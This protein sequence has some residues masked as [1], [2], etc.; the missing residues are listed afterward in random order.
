[1]HIRV[2]AD[3]FWEVLRRLNNT[4][5][6]RFAVAQ[7]PMN[8]LYI[9]IYLVLNL[10]GGGDVSWQTWLK[11]P[12]IADTTTWAL[13]LKKQRNPK[14]LMSPPAYF[15]RERIPGQKSGC[16]RKEKKFPSEK[17]CD[18]EERKSE[19]WT[20]KNGLTLDFIKCPKK[21]LPFCSLKQKA[22]I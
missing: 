21:I 22:R 18:V 15:Y 13:K 6:N 10:H 17:L 11:S 16:L 9:Y 5:Q 2:S 8:K 14:L 7:D 20:Q 4:S 19:L 1:M 12:H 3:D